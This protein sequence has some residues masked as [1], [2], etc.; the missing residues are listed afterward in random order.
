[1]SIIKLER[2]YAP[3]DSCTLGR[4]TMP[5]GYACLTIER[6]WLDNKTNVSC[7]PEGAYSL[8][9]RQSS[10]VN[11]TS[12]GE[13]TSGW[14]VRD[15]A[16]RTYIMLHPGNWAKDTN[17]CILPGDSLAS[18]PEHGLMVTNSRKTFRN[19][20]GKLEAKGEW[21]LQVTTKRGGAHA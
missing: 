10:V 16:G 2:S 9:L 1:M 11:R 3:D 12:G 19:L 20:M 18:H 4:L 15:V 6:P 14:E 17:G 13:F 7:I 8:S 21:T 5:C